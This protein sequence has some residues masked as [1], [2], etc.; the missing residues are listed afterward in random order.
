MSS[1]DLDEP[2]ELEAFWQ[3][4]R[5]KT[6]RPAHLTGKRFGRLLVVAQAGSDKHG[7]TLWRCVCD[8]G[9]TKTV[10]RTHLCSKRTQSCGCLQQV[11]RASSQKALTR[12]PRKP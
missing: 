11:Y 5:P 4:L 10:P 9:N 12:Q 3:L 1:L 7:A 2:L 8:C 6:G